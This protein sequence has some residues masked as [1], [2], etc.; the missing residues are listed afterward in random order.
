MPSRGAKG[1]SDAGRARAEIVLGNRF[2]ASASSD[3]CMQI[4]Q[5]MKAQGFQ[6][7]WN[8]P[9]KGGRITETYG[10]P[11]QGQ[12]TVQI[13]LRRDLYMDEETFQ[14]RPEFA[15][16]SKRLTEAL[17]QVATWTALNCSPV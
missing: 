8:D 12:E 2:G 13:E 10:R 11:D 1:H 4:E 7:V 16:V 14:K 15:D 5:N 17:L 9:Y 3:F 6:V